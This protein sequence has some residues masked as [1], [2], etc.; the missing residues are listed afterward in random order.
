MC[1]STIRHRAVA[2][3][4]SVTEQSYCH[5]L[6]ICKTGVPGWVNCAVTILFLRATNPEQQGCR[7][8]TPTMGD[9][10]GPPHP[11]KGPVSHALRAGTPAYPCEVE[12]AVNGNNSSRLRF[13]NEQWRPVA[14]TQRESPSL[15]ISFRDALERHML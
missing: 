9:G 14:H 6:A 10:M 11:S 5:D 2:A 4:P 7:V 12:R 3:R 1:D 8:C 13:T 15:D